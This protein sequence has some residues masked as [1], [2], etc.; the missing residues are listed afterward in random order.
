MRLFGAVIG[1]GAIALF[2]LTFKKWSLLPLALVVGIIAINFRFYAFYLSKGRRLL[3]FLLLPLHLIYY[4]YC[5]LA[6]TTGLALHFRK[7]RKE[8]RANVSQCGTA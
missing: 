5:G 8:K 7:S 3:V 6:F 1:L 2:G 4:L